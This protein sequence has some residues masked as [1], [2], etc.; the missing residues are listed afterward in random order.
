MWAFARTNNNDANLFR[1]ISINNRHFEL[2]LQK[3]SVSVNKI[4]NVH[5]FTSVVWLKCRLNIC[6]VNQACLFKRE[7]LS[8]CLLSALHR[9][10]DS[11]I[12]HPI[13]SIHNNMCTQKMSTDIF[14]HSDLDPKDLVKPKPG[15]F[16]WL[17]WPVSL[18]SMSKKCDSPTERPLLSF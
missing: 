7:F 12:P 9:K 18:F 4:S 14:S 6:A 16:V 1:W 10:R 2:F 3:P 15:S 8:I 5:P 13:P 11:L 17:R